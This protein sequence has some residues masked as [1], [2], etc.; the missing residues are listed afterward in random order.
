MET[1]HPAPISVSVHWEHKSEERLAAGKA[2][3]CGLA[4]LFAGIGQLGS[5]LKRELVRARIELA[6]MNAASANSRKPAIRLAF[7]SL[8]CKPLLNRKSTTVA[9]ASSM[10]R[11]SQNLA[12]QRSVPGQPQTLQRRPRRTSTPS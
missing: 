1:N 12:V 2:A 7:F 4:A 9:E 3:L 8:M 10:T 5:G 6:T 11:P